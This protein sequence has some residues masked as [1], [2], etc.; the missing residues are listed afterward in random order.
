M[1]FA[2]RETAIAQC[3]RVF[4]Y[5]GMQAKQSS[6][7]R[8]TG[9]GFDC[10]TMH[11]YWVKI[12]P[13]KL[14]EATLYMYIYLYNETPFGKSVEIAEITTSTSKNIVYQLLPTSI[15]NIKLKE[16]TSVLLLHTGWKRSWLGNK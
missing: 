13:I 3:M 4:V 2:F 8:R 12:E 7:I 16:H 1:V 6:T 10:L 14:S 5:V 9:N 15:Q 11:K